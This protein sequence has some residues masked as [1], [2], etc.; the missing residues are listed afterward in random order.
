[1]LFFL[2]PSYVFEWMIA[3]GPRDLL[4]YAILVA[5]LIALNLAAIVEQIE[6][7]GA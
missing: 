7:E 2:L 4:Y 6:G 3:Q 1:M 5:V